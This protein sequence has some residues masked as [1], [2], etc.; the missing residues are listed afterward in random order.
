MEDVLI[1]ILVIAFFVALFKWVVPRLKPPASFS[2][3][4]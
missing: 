4:T 3:P 1:I 2:C